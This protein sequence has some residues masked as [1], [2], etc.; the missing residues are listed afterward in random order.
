MSIKKSE[1]WEKFGKLWKQKNGIKSWNILSWEK[2]WETKKEK[3]KNKLRIARKPK[4]WKINQ[5]ILKSLDN[6]ILKLHK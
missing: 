1:N 2:S 6:L 4:K 3:V 5:K